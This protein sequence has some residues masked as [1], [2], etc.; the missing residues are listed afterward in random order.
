MV[1]NDIRKD[2]K[3]LVEAVLFISGKAMDINEISVAIGVASPGQIKN[4]LKEL[5]RDYKNAD[6][7]LSISLIGEK[8]VMD[9]KEPYGSKVNNM[10]ESVDISKSSLRILAYIS[11]NEPLMQS[12]IVRIFG[13]SAYQ[14]IKELIQNGF[15][16]ASRYGRTKKINTTQKFAEYFNLSKND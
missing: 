11:K 8:Y 6:T 10:A 15:I 9:L 7:S 2:M 1:Q 12:N 16:S 3:R 14:H 4:L 13:S 5:I